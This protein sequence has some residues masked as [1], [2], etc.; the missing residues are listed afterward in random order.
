MTDTSV[1]E[2]NGRFVLSRTKQCA[3]CPWKLDTDPFDIP[4]G[5]CPVKHANLAQTIAKPG[6]LDSTGK[7]MACHHSQPS[8]EQYCIGW[9]YHQ[10]G[11]GN[12]IPLRIRMLKCDN[13]KE[14]TIYGPQHQRFEDTLPNNSQKEVHHG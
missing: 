6:S 5:Y 11:I 10:L 13:L 2:G 1:I 4:D 12:N 3:K 7:A 9:L 8:D 14:L